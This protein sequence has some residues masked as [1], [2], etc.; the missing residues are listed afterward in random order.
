M[1]PLKIKS[2]DNSY[3][4][5]AINLIIEIQQKEFRTSITINDQPDLFEIEDYY[6]QK[7]GNFWGAFIEN[8]LVGTIALANFGNSNG[9]VRKMFVKESFRGK[10]LGIA[11]ELLN[12]LISFSSAHNITDLYL[13]TIDVFKAAQPFYER[14]NFTIINKEELP[15]SFPLMNADNLFYHLNIK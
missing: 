2:I 14:N 12:E 11:Q 6:M 10:E 3:S 9:A 4:T 1:K 13:G 7:G 5:Q 15:V 8:E